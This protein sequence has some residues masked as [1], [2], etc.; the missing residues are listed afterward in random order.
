MQPCIST[1]L[2][3][4]GLIL[5]IIGSIL[6]WWFV[7]SLFKLDKSGDI[8]VSGG[9]DKGYGC[10]LLI[11]KFGIWFLII[12]FAFQLFGTLYPTIH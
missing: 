1:I 10:N 8:V 6:L 7:P 5:N 3:V 11:S 9:D 2:N 4:I 12:G